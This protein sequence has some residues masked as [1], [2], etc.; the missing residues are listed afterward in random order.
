MNLF[1]EYII[2][3]FGCI[4]IC[5]YS[6]SISFAQI[7]SPTNIDGISAWW[8]ADSIKQEDGTLVD[9]WQSLD[10]SS[11]CVSQPI[12]EYTPTL[13]K[14]VSEIN[15]HTVLRFDGNDYLDGGNILNVG[16]IGQTAFVIAKSKS[17][18]GCFFAKSLTG[19][20]NSRYYCMYENSKPTFLVQFAKDYYGPIGDS[21]TNLYEQFTTVINGIEGTMSFF[22]NMIGIQKKET[23]QVAYNFV[24]SFNFLI[25]GYNNTSGTI[26]PNSSY[27]LN[28]DIAEL[29][30][31]DRPLTNLERQ[32]VENY[33]RAKYFPGTEREQFSFGEDVNQPYSLKPVVLSVPER[34]YFKTYKWST[35]ESTKGISVQKSGMY[36]VYV[37][38]DWG[39]EYVDTIMVSF[40]EIKYIQ[41]QT[42]CDGQSLVWD[43]GLSGD[44]MY[45]WNTGEITRA[46]SITKAG[47]YAVKVTDNEGYSLVSDTVVIEVDDFST[48][49]KLGADTAFCAGNRIGLISRVED[50]QK[51]VWSTGDTT[52][53]IAIETAGTYSLAVTN[54]R[55]CTAT[56]EI[57]V[58][59]T[60]V[61]PIAKGIS[62]YHCFGDNT[63]LLSNSYTTDNTSITNTT[64]YV[65]QDTLMGSVQ[66]YQFSQ[67]GSF[68][69]T[70]VVENEVGCSQ[71]VV[72]T[73]TIHPVPIANFSPKISCQFTANDIL[74]TSKI[75]SG[76]IVSYV[77]NGIDKTTTDSLFVFRSDEVG[78][79]PLSL[80]VVSDFG[81]SD[82]VMADVTV[83]ASSK[84]EFIHSK[85]CIGDTVLFFDISE[86]QPYNPVLSA[87]WQYG[88]K[89]LKYSDVLAIRATDTLPHPISLHVKTFNGC[90]NIAHDTLQARDVPHP[91]VQDTLFSCVNTNILLRN[92]GHSADSIA[93]YVWNVNGDI[94]TEPQPIVDFVESGVYNYTLSVQT[95][96]ECSNQT[97]GAIVIDKT[98]TADFTFYP[99]YGA[100]PLDVDFT[101]ISKDAVS[102]EW[103]FEKS[104]VSDDENPSYTFNDKTNSYAQLRALSKHGCAESVIK[105]I[106]V[107]LSDLKLQILDVVATIIK[108]QIQYTIQILN[109]GNDNIPEM[110]ISLQSPDFPTLTE[111]WFGALKA[112]AVLNYTFTTK[113]AAKNGEIPAFLCA[114]A[115]VASANQNAT[116]YQ[117][118]FCKDNSGEFMVYSIA[119]NPIEKTAQIAFNTKQ[120]GLVTI[121]C[122]DDAGKLRL[123]QDFSDVSAGFHTIQFDATQLPAGR[124]T[125]QIVQG[126]QKEQMAIMK[127]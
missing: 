22:Q 54:E 87:Y 15:N 103:T 4:L 66:S 102:Y 41:S 51:Y 58:A 121:E 98:P 100:A 89:Q 88:N 65:E 43:C 29:I 109:T 68:P 38:D 113:T 86:Y 27:F 33:L 13:I 53:V 64:W 82:E 26:P 108:G 23:F 42:I 77:W 97:K 19:L 92:D 123:S 75:A 2:R 61:A 20:G 40:P 34:E 93:D 21:R 62:Q 114:S 127:M 126:N 60:G 36:D 118:E 45:E 25:G 31:Y 12:A 80:K 91:V 71:F 9:F 84:I 16:K 74:S 5:M 106:P 17:A 7:S 30:F 111:T 48:T 79:Y 63:E 44:Y 39:Y 105:F 124:Y 52:A 90:E 95:N 37:T 104:V 47:K 8:C 107:Q 24:S 85:A 35:G 10:K 14:N 59:I 1:K 72:D 81:C 70:L 56:D 50:A 76:E 119:P 46:I 73:I 49:A 116:Y 57:Q 69:V 94:Y 83:R 32:S 101:N 99:E 6:T 110:E 11:L 120:K 122:Y 67:V 112:N 55:G 117:D 96:N 18:N 3:F 115:S 78:L 28:G 125:I